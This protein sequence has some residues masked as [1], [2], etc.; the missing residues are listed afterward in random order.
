MIDALFVLGLILVVTA[1]AFAQPGDIT[2]ASTSD[3][4]IKGKGD[5]FFRRVEGRRLVG[6][7][8]YDEHVT[9]L[10]APSR[11]GR[12]SRGAGRDPGG[13]SEGPLGCVSGDPGAKAAGG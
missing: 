11:I 3:V 10:R 12:R 9:E 13:P 6:G 5:S 1:I 8:G 7:E 4:G 2:L